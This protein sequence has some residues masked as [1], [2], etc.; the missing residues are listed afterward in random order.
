MLF[1]VCAML[2]IPGYQAIAAEEEPGSASVIIS[3]INW[4]G[5]SGST[6]D[7][8]LELYNPTSGSVDL[9]G[10]ILTGSATSG[11]AL[12]LE[13]GSVIEAGSVLLIANY[14]ASH[15]NT[16]LTI[17][18]NL[19]T[20]ALS[21]PNS[22]LD[23][24][25]AKADGTIV[26]SVAMTGSPDAGSTD[27]VASMERNLSTLEW[28][29]TVA[30]VNLSDALQFGT[31]GVIY[32]SVSA[33]E[34]EE[35]PA[36]EPTEEEVSDES[37]TEME[38]VCTPIEEEVED[39]A[40]EAPEEAEEID[41]EE[42]E[43]ATDEQEDAAEAAEEGE[44]ASYAAGTLILSEIVSD[45]EDG[46][47]WIEI[48][49][50]GG[51]AVDTS[52]WSV[53]D[54][55]EKATTLPEEDLAP[56]AY[57]VIEDPSGQ[58]NNGGD[59]VELL[60]P[61]GNIIDSLE[62]GTDEIDE[63]EKGES[64]ALIDG[65][66][67]VTEDITKGEVNIAAEINQPYAEE[68]ETET[69]AGAEDIESGADEEETNIEDD[70]ATDVEDSE[71]E[72][73]ALPDDEYECEE[74]PESV[75]VEEVHSVVAVATSSDGTSS[76][77]SSAA[78]SS[79]PGEQETL[80]SVVTATPGT[81]GSQIAFVDGMQLYFYYADWPE[82]NVGDIV[83]VIGTPSESRGEPRLKISSQDD[84]TV[85]G[86]A[87][88]TVHKVNAFEL[89]DLAEGALARVS[90]SIFDRDGDRLTLE[91][92][93][94]TIIVIGHERTDVSWSGLDGSEL[95]ITGV[96]RHIDGETRIYPRS[97]DDVEVMEVS[98]EAAAAAPIVETSSAKPWIGLGLLAGT[99]GVLTYWL[100]RRKRR[101]HGVA[102]FPLM[103]KTKSTLT[104]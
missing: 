7:E 99:L 18:P 90:G 41:A 40:A 42:T 60:D 15:E 68:E 17:E 12:A 97:M 23:I 45:P 53:R 71:D 102:S 54:A 34:S 30:N 100:V 66:W 75:S 38:C 9:S 76:T 83:E 96:V 85:V 28:F 8:W 65:A 63:P 101:Q 31:P 104:Q 27:P 58:L 61:A 47:E 78:T 52:D 1:F 20:T 79:S 88:P 77:Y 89:T 70:S 50:P 59:T 21:L 55:T 74:T 48:N 103:A 35:E 24:M 73:A 19:V 4:A 37:D 80:T 22:G 2:S 64:L 72:Y 29:T 62:Y 6:A 51:E 43:A 84:I 39:V 69:D 14:D 26:D 46:V 92:E 10:W 67:V 95:T 36:E 98:D 57:L 32:A 3:E 13:G 81:L 33:P 86:V 56:G 87:E 49:N 16:T 93:Y 25:L 44:P 94:G 91:D 5:S 11:D 82:I